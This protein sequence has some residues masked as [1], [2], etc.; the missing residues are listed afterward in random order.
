[1]IKFYTLV[2]MGVCFAFFAD[3]STQDSKSESADDIEVVDVHFN[4]WM[5]N[6]TWALESEMGAIRGWIELKNESNASVKLTD[7]KL[8]NASSEELSFDLSE[9]VV[10]PK[11][12][13]LLVFTDN[14][15]FKLEN[16]LALPTHMNL[17]SDQGFS[18]IGPKGL[19][20]DK[21]HYEGEHKKDVSIGK[22]GDN[23]S[24]P[25]VYMAKATPGKDNSDG[26]LEYSV[27]EPVHS[28]ARGFYAE[29]IE[30]KV[31]P[32]GD[33]LIYATTDGSTP[34]VTSGQ[35]LNGPLIISDTSIVRSLAVERDGSQSEVVTHT[36]IFPESLL[37]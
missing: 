10:G 21:M 16:G 4:E 37:A 18:M 35:E 30:L 24:S 5:A 29:P 19:V 11:G 26:L 17:K 28:V 27:F 23:Q 33:A 12:Y 13:F 34:V 1:M 7:H 3:C 20:L 25:M 14:T 15:L 32:K 22:V 31:Q 8:I 36:Y 6:N 2:F 9:V